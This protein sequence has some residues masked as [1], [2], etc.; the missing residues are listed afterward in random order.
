MHYAGT[1]HTFDG[2]LLVPTYSAAAPV[3][4][5]AL[6]RLTRD[7]TLNTP[8]LSS[9]MDRPEPVSPSSL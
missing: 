9:A 5:S 2:V 3:W 6:T 7:S 4:A 8:L 1:K